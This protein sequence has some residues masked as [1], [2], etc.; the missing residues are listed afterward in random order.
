MPIV[1]DLVLFL[2]AAGDDIEGQPPLFN[3][4]GSV[5]DQ[6][7]CEEDKEDRRES[8]HAYVLELIFNIL[9]ISQLALNQTLPSSLS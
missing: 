2:L 3:L 5:A 6:G 1:F 9:M 8:R 7:S 4:Y